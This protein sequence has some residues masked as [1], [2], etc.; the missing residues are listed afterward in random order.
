MSMTDDYEDALERRL[1]VLST[2]TPRCHVE[3][4]GETNPFALTGTHPHEVCYE[5]QNDAAGRPV[6]EDQHVPGQHNS[7]LTVPMLGND[8]RVADS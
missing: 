4:C 5:H 1:A 6:V 8:H 7:P 3:G 2:R